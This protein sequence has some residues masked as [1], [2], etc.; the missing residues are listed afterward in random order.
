[1]CTLV[2]S[3]I[4]LYLSA[5]SVQ[6]PCI[7]PH[8]RYPVW[9]GH[10]KCINSYPC[11]SILCILAFLLGQHVPV[12]NFFNNWK[13]LAATEPQVTLSQ[14]QQWCEGAVI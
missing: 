6:E 8:S 13:S 3:Q 12:A 5:G 11:N 14:E 10:L 1:M 2:I 4:V 9:L 7:K